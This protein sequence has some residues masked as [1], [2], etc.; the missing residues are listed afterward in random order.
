[1]PQPEQMS[2]LAQLKDEYDSLAESEQFAVVVSTLDSHL[3]KLD[4]L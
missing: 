2:Q 4:K 1:M 3:V